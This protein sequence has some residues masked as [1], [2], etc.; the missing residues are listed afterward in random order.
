MTILSALSGVIARST[1]TSKPCAIGI[2][3][4]VVFIDG[5]VMSSPLW[6]VST[7]EA[8]AAD[9]RRQVKSALDVRFLPLDRISDQ[10]PEYYTIVDVNLKNTPHLLELKEWL[11]RKPNGGKAIFLTDKSSRIESMQA[12][13]LGATDV[14]HHPLREQELMTRLRGEFT[15]LVDDPP[16]LRLPHSPGVAEAVGALQSIFLSA[17]VGGHLD[18]KSI[19]E[20]GEA[21]VGQIETQGLASWIDIVRKHHSQTYQHCLLVTGVAVAFGQ[22]LGLSLADRQRLSFAGMLHDIGKARIPLSI[23]EKPGP[24]NQDEIAVMR[25]HPQHG[26]DALQGV[27]V[28]SEMLD[29]VVHHHEYLDGSGYPHGLVASEIADLVRIMTIADIFGALIERRSYKAPLSGEAAYQ[30]FSTW[31]QSSTKILFVNFASRH[32]CN[33]DGRVENADQRLVAGEPPKRTSP[34]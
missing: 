3:Q 7:C 19:N 23:L 1:R 28:A 16:G 21:I 25:Q 12:F 10:T 15:S 27:D 4:N 30:F 5:H 11:K 14:M 26:V 17:C 13:A 18:P 20:A 33:A 29:M 34:A 9:L 2:R 8:G 24:L 31:G 32:M 6:F 22:Q